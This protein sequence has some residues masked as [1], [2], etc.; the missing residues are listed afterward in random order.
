MKTYGKLMLVMLGLLLISTNSHSIEYRYRTSNIVDRNGYHYYRGAEGRDRYYEEIYYNNTGY[1]TYA[2]PIIGH[3]VYANGYDNYNS[4][5]YG[6][7]FYNNE[8]YMHGFYNNGY[9]NPGNCRGA[10]CYAGN[11]G[12]K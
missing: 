2:N 6:G 8:Y 12:M 7:G 5:Y 9:Y 1:Y 3:D 4:G 11:R 10:N